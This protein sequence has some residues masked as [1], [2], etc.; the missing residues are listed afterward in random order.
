MKET[1]ETKSAKGIMKEAKQTERLVPFVKDVIVKHVDLIR[2][3]MTVD[4]PVDF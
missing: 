3:E 1:K 4:W 2:R